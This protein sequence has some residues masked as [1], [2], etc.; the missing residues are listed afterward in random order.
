M[1]IKDLRKLAEEHLE[2]V[3]NNE[4]SNSRAKNTTHALGRLL[5]IELAEIKYQQHIG[6]KK[7][8]PFFEGEES[9]GMKKRVLPF[10]VEQK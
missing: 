7:E 5:A 8:I 2:K 6:K 3:V 10:E 1:T 9:E 4:L